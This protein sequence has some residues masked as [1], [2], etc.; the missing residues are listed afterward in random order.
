MPPHGV[1]VAPVAMN[2]HASGLIVKGGILE[3]KVHGNRAVLPATASAAKLGTPDYPMYPCCITRRK[4]INGMSTALFSKVSPSQGR[5]LH[6]GFSA[7]LHRAPQRPFHPARKSHR[8]PIRTAI[9]MVM[10]ES[11]SLEP[12]TKAPSFK[13]CVTSGQKAERNCHRGWLC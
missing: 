9:V 2:V 13:V 8:H 4:H 7:T 6:R 12:G 1:N 3:S 5:A 10:T 11:K